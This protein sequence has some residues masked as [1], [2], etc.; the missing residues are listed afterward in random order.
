MGKFS[1]GSEGG[2]CYKLSALFFSHQPLLCLLLS[3]ALVRRR[4]VKNLS[5]VCLHCTGCSSCIAEAN[6]GC[7]TSLKRNDTY[8]YSHYST[9]CTAQPSEPK[10]LIFISAAVKVL[11]FSDFV[12]KSICIT[13]VSNLK[14]AMVGI[15]ELKQNVCIFIFVEPLTKFYTTGESQE[16]YIKNKKKSVCYIITK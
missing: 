8:W 2:L 7:Q 1:Q 5:D 6:Q 15:A 13:L 9:S 12:L 14:T 16:N 11:V 4:S 3:E 10:W